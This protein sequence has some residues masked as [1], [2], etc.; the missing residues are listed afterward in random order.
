MV[1][2]HQHGTN[3]ASEVEANRIGGGTIFTEKHKEWIRSMVDRYA[4][5]GWYL[6]GTT[7]YYYDE[8]HKSSK[9]C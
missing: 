7:R 6:D 9:K 5:T 4:I 8:N 2:I 3:T 1:G